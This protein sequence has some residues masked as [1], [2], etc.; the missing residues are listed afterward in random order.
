MVGYGE[1][2]GPEA[3]RVRY[4]DKA[5]TESGGDYTAGVLVSRHPLTGRFY[6]EHAIR[7]Q[8]S[9]AK[10]NAIIRNIA[11]MDAERYG[12]VVQIWLEQE[13]GSGGKESAWISMQ[14]LAEFPVH[15]E[16]VS[17][18]GKKAVRAIPLQAQAEVGNVDV[19][20][21]R[22]T[23]PWMD[24]MC[25]FPEGNHDDYVD[26]TSGAYRKVAVL[27]GLDIQ[28]SQ[29]LVLYPEPEEK[30]GGKKGGGGKGMDGQSDSATPHL[31]P[32]DALTQWLADYAGV[33]TGK[34]KAAAADPDALS[35]TP[36][37]LP[38]TTPATPQANTV[39]SEDYSPDS[40]QLSTMQRYAAAAFGDD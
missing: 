35:A 11:R 16:T 28:G 33:S 13:P 3:V 19:V 25:G 27:S 17:R 23:G 36:A 7:G 38:A 9:P 24:Q 37:A 32:V 20:E 22:W 26:A 14:E 12:G 31:S 40:P 39:S 2:P 18:K 5:A 4:W 29:P 34:A 21:A 10:R 30:K 1:L 6:I 8:W 15:V